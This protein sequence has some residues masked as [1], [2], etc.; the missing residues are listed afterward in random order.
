[1]KISLILI[2]VIFIIFWN[3]RIGKRSLEIWRVCVEGVFGV[4][5]FCL[6][7]GRLVRGGLD[8]GLDIVGLS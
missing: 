4:G 7:W 8:L 2:Y 6:G 1:M 5:F 3:F